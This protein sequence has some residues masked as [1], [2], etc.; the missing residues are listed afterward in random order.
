VKS[1]DHRRP[2]TFVF[3]VTTLALG[4]ACNLATNAVTI[5]WPWWPA[6][7]WLAVA[8]LSMIAVGEYARN[9]HRGAAAT[10]DEVIRQASASGG[11]RRRRQAKAA[12][13]LAA[14]GTGYAGLTQLHETVGAIA[15]GN[16]DSAATL[17]RSLGVLSER[18]GRYDLAADHALQM[19]IYDAD[20]TEG[21]I[22][23]S[24]V[25]QAY[26]DTVKRYPTRVVLSGHPD[27]VRNLLEALAIGLVSAMIV[28]SDPF[29]PGQ[30]NA[31]ARAESGRLTGIIESFSREAA[32][33]SPSVA[34]MVH[35]YLLPPT[36]EYRRAVK[37]R[38]ARF[39]PGDQLVDP[40]TGASVPRTNLDYDPDTER[41]Y[42]EQTPPA[43]ASR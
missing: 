17:V 18:A 2:S 8:L 26:L 20:R 5:T 31:D 24:L 14:T 38:T 35:E 41:G 10:T 36:D 19:E 23:D 22:A 43:P 29:A 11:F 3:L 27:G 1:D 4:L 13:R 39:V 33:A 16:R 7:T 28:A 6:V 42:L 21:R 34:Q 9:R 32:G 12:A 15:R 30:E 25:Q 37:G 40:V